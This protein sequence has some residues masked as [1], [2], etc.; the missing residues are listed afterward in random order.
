[1]ME[2][3][4]PLAMLALIFLAGMS[5]L[6]SCSGDTEEYDPYE[7]W[8]VRN[9]A[10][11]EQKADSAR[12]NKDGQWLMLKS[13]DMSPTFQSGKTADSICVHIIKHGTGTVT[14]YYTDSIRVN[15]R[16]WLMPTINAQGK[17]EELTFTQTYYG[18]FDPATAA[19]QLATVKAFTS[20][21]ATALQYMV[22]GDDWIV[23]IP[24]ELFYGSSASG[25]I[26]AYSAARFR[27]QLAA[28]Y[29]TGSLVPDWK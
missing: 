15:F 5:A 24:Q 6:T 17:Q 23:Y 25:V 9:A 3:R 29:P 16:G 19:P 27:I 28:I 8:Q 11:F 4:Q 21:F 12:E 7:N 18:D 22:V 2:Y 26:P 20:G 13:L 10:W 14:P 1:M